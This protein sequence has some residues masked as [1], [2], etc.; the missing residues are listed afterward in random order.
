MPY[1]VLVLGRP[2]CDLV[3]TGLPGWPAVGRET[4]AGGFAVSAGGAFNAVAALHRLGLRVG[5]LGPVGTDAWSRFT[6]T[7]MAAEGV[8]TE[9]MLHL[10][11]PL[12][13]VS[14]CMTHGGDRGFLTYE[15]PAGE[16]EDAVREHAL[17]VVE[18]ERADSLLTWLAPD[19]PTYAVAARNRGMR[20]VVDCGWDEHWLA[21]SKLRSVLPLADVVFANCPEACAIAGEEDPLAALRWLGRFV[22]YVVVKRGPDGASALVAGR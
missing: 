17:A 5:M 10:D 6:L 8:S 2:S 18:R 11:R 16:V 19:L 9:L 14:V 20:M 3:F 15:A 1:D 7:A 21:S 13:A 12:P 4:F 22:P